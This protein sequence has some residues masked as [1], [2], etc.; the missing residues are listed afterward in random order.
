LGVVCSGVAY[1]YAREV[2]P[3]ASFLKLGFSYPLPEKLVRRFAA[4]VKEILVIEELDPFIEEQLLAMHLGVPVQ[5]K[6]I[7]GHVGELGAEIIREKFLGQKPQLIE[8]SADIPGRPPVMC[9][10]CSHRGVFFTLRRLKVNVTGDIGCYTLGAL[11]PLEAI[12]SCICMGASIGTSLGMVR[13][14]PAAAKK[15]VAVIGDS[16]FLHSGITPLLDAVYNRAPVTVIIL[17]NGITAMTGHQQHPGTG[18]N[19]KGEE[20]PAVELENLCR[21]LGVRRVTVVDAFDLKEVK[22]VIKEELAAAEP[23]VII[24]RRPCIFLLSSFDEPLFV[25]EELC[26]GCRAC[27]ALG[28]PALSLRDGKARINPTICNG[29]GLCEQLCR[30]EAIKFPAERAGEQSE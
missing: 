29:C 17:D 24:A 8:G 13:A 19:L 30:F 18:L 27:L 1:Q 15:T 16:T 20:A 28:C 12:D 26:N 9:P 4:R 21:S 22:T 14:D 6:E 11:K 7:F 5:G 25:D 2:L 3:E 10:G 23:S